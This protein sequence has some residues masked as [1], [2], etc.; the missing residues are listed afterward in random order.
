[1]CAEIYK[2]PW[3]TIAVFSVESLFLKIYEI[4]NFL[5]FLE[6]HCPQPVIDHGQEVYKSK[7][8]YSAGTRVRMVCDEG[9]ALRGDEQIECKDDQNW[10]PSVPF[11]DKGTCKAAAS[12]RRIVG[13]FPREG[14][15]GGC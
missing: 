8:D 14:T 5:L 12:P 2:R 11:C 10:A 7:N 13:A 9:Y 3:M 15:R 1:M 4:L 6:P